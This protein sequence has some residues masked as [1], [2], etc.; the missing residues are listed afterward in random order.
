MS[1]KTLKGSIFSKC[2]SNWHFGKKICFVSTKSNFKLISKLSTEVS[3]IG[4]PI[5]T[6][7]KTSS[8]AI[9][10]KIEWSLIIMENNFLM[11]NK[12]VF[13]IKNVNI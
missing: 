4:L 12:N 9:C 6:I 5:K 3:D 11:G 13:R 2:G 7:I 1:Q 8:L 10:R